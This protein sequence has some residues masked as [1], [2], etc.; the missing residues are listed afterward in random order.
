MSP[1]RYIYPL[2]DFEGLTLRH[3]L[4]FSHNICFVIALVNQAGYVVWDLNPLNIGIN[5]QDGT[6]AC[7]GTDAYHFEDLRFGHMYRCKDALSG[8]IAPELLSAFKQDRTNN[9]YSANSLLNM[10]LPTFTKE[11]DN[12]A[13]AFLIFRLLMNGCSPYSGVLEDLPGSI[14]RLSPD[15]AVEKTPTTLPL[16][17]S[18]YPRSCQTLH[19]Y[20]QMYRFCLLVLLEMDMAHQQHVP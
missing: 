19:L 12:F 11:T 8:Y 3:K 7:Y 16:G 6:V 4:I 14:L 17:T 20:I 10:P 1:F 15:E 13:L 5:I 2:H 18:R 9:P